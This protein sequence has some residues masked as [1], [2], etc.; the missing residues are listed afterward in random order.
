MQRFDSSHK[1]LHFLARERGLSFGMIATFCGKTRQ[2][3]FN[4]DSHVTQCSAED[5]EKLNLC[6]KFVNAN[7]IMGTPKAHNLLKENSLV[8]KSFN[9]STEK[10]D[11]SKDKKR[12][13][14]KK[15]QKT[16]EKPVK[17]TDTTQEFG[18]GGR[19]R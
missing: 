13:T 12:D 15:P 9:Q 16:K 10:D 17:S 5:L 4:I 18:G 7:K 1:I 14:K 19:K 3:W 2:H 11:M 8:L 6:K